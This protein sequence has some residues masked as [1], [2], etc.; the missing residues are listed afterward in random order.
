MADTKDSLESLEERIRELLDK[1]EERGGDCHQANS[2][3]T[4]LTLYLR[5]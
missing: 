1:D 4:E 3:R 2:N 5:L